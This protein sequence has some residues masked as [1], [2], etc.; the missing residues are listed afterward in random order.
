MPRKRQK[1]RLRRWSSCSSTI[2]WR[3]RPVASSAPV[4]VAPR[5]HR[6]TGS[7]RATSGFSQGDLNARKADRRSRPTATEI[8][9]VKPKPPPRLRRSR[10]AEQVGSDNAA[11]AGP[12]RNA[13]TPTHS[14][15]YI[16]LVIRMIPR[17]AGSRSSATRAASIMPEGDVIEGRYQIL[18]I[19]VESIELSYLDGRG[20]QTI[21]Q[22]GQ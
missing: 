12:M 2:I 17:S 1:L 5:R 18:K 3:V 22:T 11:D 14:L 10:N 19:G 20:R 13:T 4:P 6:S 15:K 16:G 9:S 8:L 7:S 21:R